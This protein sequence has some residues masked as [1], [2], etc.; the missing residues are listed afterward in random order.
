MTV[1]QGLASEQ[2][3]Q[4]S[5]RPFWPVRSVLQIMLYGATVLAIPETVPTNLAY[6]LP[7]AACALARSDWVAA[8][9]RRPGP[10]GPG[11]GPCT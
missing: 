6:L 11:S 2:A 10:A 3:N 7:L 5:A 9:A 4:Y 8:S 1:D